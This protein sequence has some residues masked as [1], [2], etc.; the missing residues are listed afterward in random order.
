MRAARHLTSRRLLL[1]I[2]RTLWRRR[3]RGFEEQ[4]EEEE[5]EAEETESSSGRSFAPD[6]LNVAAQSVNFGWACRRIRAP[7]ARAAEVDQQKSSGR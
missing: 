3:S 2:A 1:S 4:E 5:E 7:T 6:G